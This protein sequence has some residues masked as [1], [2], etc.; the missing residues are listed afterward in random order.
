[1]TLIPILVNSEGWPDSLISELLRIGGYGI[2][3]D[4]MECLYV[5]GL[6]F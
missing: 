6:P 4:G 2:S 5:I 1:M 3:T